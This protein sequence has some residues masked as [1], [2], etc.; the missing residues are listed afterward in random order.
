[1][2]NFLLLCKFV[3][4]WDRFKFIFYSNIEFSKI[5]YYIFNKFKLN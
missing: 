3:D 1:M 5:E 2:K 4:L